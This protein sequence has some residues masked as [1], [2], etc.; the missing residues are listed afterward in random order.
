VIIGILSLIISRDNLE[1]VIWSLSIMPYIFTVFFILIPLLIFIICLFKA[2]PDVST[3]EPAN[4]PD[5]L[6]K[7]AV[8][9]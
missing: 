4:S 7:Q 1:V 3:P 8:N 9:G 2:D 6:N 5:L